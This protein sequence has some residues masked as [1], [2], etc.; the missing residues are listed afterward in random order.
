MKTL[1]PAV[2]RG[3]IRLGAPPRVEVFL[4]DDNQ[5][6]PKGKETHV[7]WLSQDEAKELGR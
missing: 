2:S 5:V 1:P 4:D 6:V 3:Y 7:I